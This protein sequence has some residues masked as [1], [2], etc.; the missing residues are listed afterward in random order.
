MAASVAA[1]GS[2][3]EL[4]VFPEIRLRRF[5]ESADR[6]AAAVAE[7]HLIAVHLEDLLFGELLF[8]LQGDHD[9]GRLCGASCAPA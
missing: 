8:E 7:I 1:S 6:E 5:A 2:V 3:S 9:F 4:K